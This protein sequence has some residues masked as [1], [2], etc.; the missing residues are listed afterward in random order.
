MR[1]LRLAHAA[2]HRAAHEHRALLGHLLGLLLAH[3][4]AQQVGAAERVAG[5]HLRDLH[6]LFL[7]EDHA[8]GRLE[9]RLQVRVQ[10]VDGR[11]A[12][13]VLARDE[14]LDHA[15]LQRAGPEQR[16]QR[17]DVAEAVGLQPP[18]QILHAARFELEH[19][20]GLAAL[21]ELDRSRH[22]PCGS[23]LMSSGGSPACARRAL[24]SRTAQSMMVS[25]R[26]PEEVELDQAG[27]LDVV[28]VELRDRSAAALFAVQRREVGEHGGR[29]H[30][31]AGVHAGVARQALERA[32]EVDE[33]AHV[34]IAR[35][36]GA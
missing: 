29:D 11:A 20:G 34:G 28:L 19:R 27:G 7:V 5:E 35:R 22:R 12:R 23:A 13:V 30:H 21:Q 32:R 4:A 3:R 9:H 15:R 24:M 33:L 2:R 31:A 26:R 17:D 25:V 36:R 16:D 8:V 18:D 6:D 14:V 10:I 1:R